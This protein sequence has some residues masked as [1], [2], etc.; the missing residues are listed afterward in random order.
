MT[1]TAL[2][3]ALVTG[4]AG[5]LT[6][7]EPG[8]PDPEVPERARRRTFTAAYKQEILAAYDAAPGGEK[9][10]ILRREGL[11]SRPSSTG[12]T[13]RPGSPRSSTRERTARNSSPG[14]TTTTG[15]PASACTPPPTSST[16]AT[17]QP[18]RPCEP[19]PSPPHTAS[20]PSASSASPRPRPRSPPAQPSTRP[21][22][23]Q[24]PLS[25]SR[26]TALIQVDG[27]RGPGTGL[28]ARSTRPGRLADGALRQTDSERMVPVDDDI[29]DLIG[30]IAE[31]RSPR[32][33]LPHLATAARPSSCSPNTDRVCPRTPSAKS[34]RGP[35]APLAS[36]TRPRTSCAAPM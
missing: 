20:T 2:D 33:D 12:R 30:H 23:K 31:I 5:Q 11:H 29:L 32:P 18:S 17:P 14:I 21:A 26:L 7:P 6:D 19:A 13:S 9:G 36:A 35:P 16:T 27:F 4:N 10:A 25:K 28:R 3:R 24:P 22:R 1:M 8:R 15:T 34:S